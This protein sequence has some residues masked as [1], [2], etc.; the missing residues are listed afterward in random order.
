M[1]IKRLASLFI[2]TPIACSQ[3]V[4]WSSM[5]SFSGE[6]WKMLVSHKAAHALALL[7]TCRA[8]G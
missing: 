2:S 1:L 3:A 4:A 5:D 8:A 7:A 6:T